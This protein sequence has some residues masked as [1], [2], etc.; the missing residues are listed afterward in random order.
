MTT[1]IY[2][3]DDIKVWFTAQIDRGDYGPGTC[4]AD[5]FVD[6]DI[7]SV[8]I[9]GVDV[10]LSELPMKLRTALHGLADSVDFN[11]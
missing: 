6:I 7:H 10:Q 9:L 1:A 11:A 8:E 5:E 2:E 3:S 4:P